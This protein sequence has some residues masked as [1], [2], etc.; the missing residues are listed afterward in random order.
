MNGEEP[1]PRRD[2]DVL[3][4]ATHRRWIGE[5]L[6]AAGSIPVIVDAGMDAPVIPDGVR[7]AWWTPTE[8]AARLLHAGAPLA[9]S[10]PGPHWLSQVP[11]ELAGRVVWSGFARD[12]PAGA[13]WC[14]L[15]EVKLEGIPAA[16]WGDTRDFTRALAAAGVP[17]ESVVQVS[18]TRLDIASEYRCFMVDGSPAAVSAYLRG[19][20]TWDPAWEGEPD[21]GAAQARAF[22][23]AVGDTM[24][25]R[26]P[27]GYVLDVAVLADG[28]WVVVEANPAWSSSPYGADPAGVVESVL[29]ANTPAGGQFAW[30]V[31]PWLV[32]YAS[33]RRV[34]KRSSPAWSLP[35]RDFPGS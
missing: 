25:S 20:V 28:N 14:K 27:A 16:W 1:E 22:A 2:F 3:V 35:S 31:D 6:A 24:G 10:A 21:P 32:K 12:V 30:Q 11:R 29:A 8:H 26:Q 13:G 5:H 23:Q 9:L 17:D 18:S 4:A 15:A 34:L 19:G 7:A 33:V